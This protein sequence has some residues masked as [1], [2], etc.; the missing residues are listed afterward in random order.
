MCCTF[1]VNMDARKI[2]AE[3]YEERKRLDEAIAALDRIAAST[4]HRRRGR[5]PKWLT[6]ADYTRVWTVW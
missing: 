2:L 3:L 1:G 4:G 6:E 5:P